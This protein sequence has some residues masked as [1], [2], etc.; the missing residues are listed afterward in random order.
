MRV[1]ARRTLKVFWEKHRRAEQPLKSWFREASQAN[2]DS[3]EE[4]KRRYRDASFLQG[5]R[6]LFNVGGN[7]YR[8]IVHANYT[9]RALYI[10]FVGTHAEY[11]CIDPEH[12]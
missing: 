10:R 2:W 3:P 7:K 6:V 11:D 4:I 8:L 12:I 1:I 5:N 9:Y